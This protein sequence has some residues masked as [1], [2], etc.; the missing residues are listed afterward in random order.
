MLLLDT[1][2]CVFALIE[3]IF[4]F[5]TYYHRTKKYPTFSKKVMPNMDVFDFFLI[6]FILGL[7]T[8]W[9][10]GDFEAGSTGGRLLMC[11]RGLRI[12]RLFPALTR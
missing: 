6:V 10:V 2:F 1:F 8:F 9:N 4:R 11:S 5:V 12:F 3:V 7:S